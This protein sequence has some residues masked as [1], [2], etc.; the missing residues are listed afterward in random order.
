MEKLKVV[1]EENKMLNQMQYEGRIIKILL[2]GIVDLKYKISAHK[3]IFP[4]ENIICELREIEREVY[5]IIE[6][7]SNK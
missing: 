2:D 3:G 7:G 4:K 6:S 1:I 5:N